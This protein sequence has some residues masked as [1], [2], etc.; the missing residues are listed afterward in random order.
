MRLN[1]KLITVGRISIIARLQGG[2][3]KSLCEDLI[4]ANMKMFGPV[5]F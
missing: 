2:E 4:M 3:K 5:S 1:V